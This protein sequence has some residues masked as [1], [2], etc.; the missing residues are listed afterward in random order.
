MQQGSLSIRMEPSLY[1][2]GMPYCHLGRCEEAITAAKRYMELTGGE[3]NAYDSLGTD[4]A[5]IGR[6]QEAE[7]A[8]NAAIARKPDS[9]I[10]RFHLGHPAF[11]AGQVC[12]GD[13]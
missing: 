1:N 4:Y 12:A 10:P 2:L 9:F 6:Y 13:F 5:W 3:A 11:L 8:Y 7:Q